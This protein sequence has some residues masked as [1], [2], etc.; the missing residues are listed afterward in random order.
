MNNFAEIV[1]I[2]QFE[3][4][5]YY[6]IAINESDSLYDSFIEKHSAENK[7]KLHHILA[8][9]K[10]IGNKT[11]ALDQYFRNEAE[12]ADTRALPPIG[13]DRPPVF[14]EIDENG[15]NEN[16]AN[17]L[18]LYCMRANEH[19]VFLFNGDIKTVAKAQN[20]PN[21]NLHFKMANKLT[22][23][24]TDAFVEGDIRWINDYVDIE[25]D[26]DFLLEWN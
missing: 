9:I 20:C 16:V 2:E 13:K 26:K 18:R 8:W 25:F 11:G 22:K 1:F 15:R 10:K 23:L 19:V 14:V 3:K 21:V 24:L 4:V 6:S 7:D 5:T 17:N 12:T